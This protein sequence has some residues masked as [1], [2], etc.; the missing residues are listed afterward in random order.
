MYEWKINHI[1]DG[2][3]NEPTSWELLD[4]FGEVQ[5]YVDFITYIGY[6]IK[7]SKWNEIAVFDGFE[8]AKNYVESL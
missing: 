8:E 6:I 4:E 5:Y 1:W 2:E 7:D 3:E